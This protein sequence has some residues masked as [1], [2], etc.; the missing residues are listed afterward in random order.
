MSQTADSV[1]RAYLRLAF[2]IERFVPGFIDAY[3]GLPEWKAEAGAEVKVEPGDLRRDAEVLLDDIATLSDDLRREWLTRQVT[4]MHATLRRVQGE[5]ISFDDELRLLYDIQPQ[6]T[7]EREFDEAL[8]VVGD[9]LPGP[10][11]EPLADR[12]DAWD[13]QFNVPTENLVPLFTVARDQAQKLARRLFALPEGEEIVLQIVANQP[14]SAY[15]WYLGNYRSRVDLNTDLPV[16]ANSMVGLMTHEGY[17][18][19]HT[20]HA[21]KE[22]LLYRAQGHAE[23]CVQLINAPECVISEGIADSAREMILTDEELDDWLRDVFYPLAG[24]QVALRVA[25][26]RVLAQARRKLRALS[27]NAAFLLHREGAD[28]ETVVKYIQRFGARTDK[29]ARQSYRFIS[30]P[31]FRSY[32]FTYHYGRDLLARYMARGDRLARF[33]TCLEQPLTPSFLER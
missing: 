20:E 1:S 33:K 11:G 5:V 15:N 9:V 17:P 14:W 3:F 18:G 7:D 13:N 24:L 4:A 23:A 25:R 29:Q 32:I 10:A 8:R 30:N 31:L 28:P 2:H 12:L 27:G 22:K 26:D 6:W 16:R 19:H 21:L